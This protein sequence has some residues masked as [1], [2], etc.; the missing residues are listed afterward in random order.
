[1][2]DMLLR[3]YAPRPA[4]TTA[5]TRIERP[6]FPVIDAH[7]HLG[8]L[9]PG[10]SF[11]GPWPSRPVHELV[12]VL[13]QAGIVAIVNLDGNYGELLRAEIER[14][15]DP[16]PD[17]FVV[18]AGIDYEAFGREHDIGAYL[19]HQLRDSA[20]AG[21]QG[22]KIWK[23]LGLTIR[24]RRGDLMAVNDARLDELWATAGE[25]GLPV[26][27]HTADPVAF[28][29]PLDRFNERY[30][31]LI[32]HPDWHFYGPQFPSFEELIGQLADII[33]RH[34]NTTFIGAH[35]GCYAENL[36][37]VSALL[38]RCPNAYIDFSAR[39]P[40]LGRQPYAARDFFI[41]HADRILF[42]TDMPADP[43]MYRLY[44]RFLESRDEY[45]AYDLAPIPTQGRWMIY[46]LHLPDE[47][48]EQVY[49]LNARRVLKID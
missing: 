17:R 4:L 34:P 20:A 48:L 19:A 38:N 43:E 9:I 14:Y 26:L 33:E 5:V 15:R 29:Q 6:R 30:E 23:P 22:L 40:E 21:A 39:V 42:G 44:Y 8:E 32:A 41:R 18:F 12:E 3:D 7:N 24:D 2:N 25:L 36:G 47:V 35:V 13:D 27:I 49:H 31:Q 10:A 37:W 11:A 46:G 16:Y 45:F 28:F 1:M